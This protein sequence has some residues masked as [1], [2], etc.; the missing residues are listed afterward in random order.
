MIFLLIIL[1][2]IV[3]I[4]PWPKSS[5]FRWL[6]QTLAHRGLFDEHH[7]ENTFG[8]F[9]LAINQGL[10]IEC[11]LRLTTD[12]ILV[13]FHDPH[14]KRLCQSDLEVSKSTYEEIKTIPILNTSYTIMKLEEFL[15]LVSGQVPIMLEIKPNSRHDDTIDTLY[16]QLK[17]Y[18]G[19][20]SIVS[21]DPRIVKACKKRIGNQYPIGQIIE[22]QFTNKTIPYYQRL[23]LTIN[24]FQRITKADFISVSTSMWPY[25][26]WMTW[27]S[28][29]VGVWPVRTVN[30][31]KKCNRNNIAIVEKEAL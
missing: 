24:A 27:F 10:G 31:L 1:V 25:Y 23:I 13:V 5:K 7:P 4:T 22:Q 9:Q 19:L 8:A 20:V 11:D 29:M 15:N 28:I 18:Q 6:R 3:L 2:L 17:D 26:Q 14:L 21:F 12:N 30:Q 16:N